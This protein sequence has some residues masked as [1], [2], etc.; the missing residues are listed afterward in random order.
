ESYQQTGIYVARSIID[1]FAGR[2]IKN[3]L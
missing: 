3:V 2:E 1:F